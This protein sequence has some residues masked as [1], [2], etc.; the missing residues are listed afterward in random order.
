MQIF[1]SLKACL[2]SAVGADIRIVIYRSLVAF[3][4]TGAPRPGAQGRGIVRVENSQFVSSLPGDDEV[5]AVPGP[6]VVEP[7]ISSAQM[8]RL[9]PAAGTQLFIREAGASIVLHLS[10][11]L[12]GWRVFNLT[13]G[14]SSSS[15]ETD[16]QSFAKWK[17]GVVGP[18]GLP[19]WLLTVG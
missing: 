19:Y 16:A 7:D 1:P 13:A 11:G 17:V 14:T 10:G 8:D 9:G 3:V 5:L 2:L 6:Y 4:G 15:V 18:S 12:P